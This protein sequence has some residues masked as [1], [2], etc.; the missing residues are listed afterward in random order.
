MSK[1]VLA[2]KN[3]AANK[4]ISHIGLGVSAT[5]GQ[6]FVRSLVKQLSKALQSEFAFIVETIMCAV[7]TAVPAASTRGA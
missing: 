5:T 1:L 3:F 7:L 4:N 6:E 2:Y